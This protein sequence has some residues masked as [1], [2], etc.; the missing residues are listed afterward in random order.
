[1]RRPKP[2]DPNEPFIPSF[3]VLLVV[4]LLVLTSREWKAGSAGKNIEKWSKL[5]S[6]PS[7]KLS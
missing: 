5:R 3:Y 7:S 4:V 1:M 2:A 6:E